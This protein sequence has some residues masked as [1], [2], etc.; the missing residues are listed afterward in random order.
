MQ[1][2]LLCNDKYTIYEDGTYKAIKLQEMMLSLAFTINKLKRE[3]EIL[4]EE[5]NMF[6]EDIDTLNEQKEAL[7]DHL[8]EEEVN[9][10]IAKSRLS[11]KQALVMSLLIEG[12]D[13]QEIADA[14]FISPNTV[15]SYLE[16]IYEK[17]NL[18]GDNRKIKAILIYLGK[19]KIEE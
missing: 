9:K 12:K 2:I 11:E 4:R 19:R 18:K 5:N 7:V 16:A 1:D 13:N 3:T 8:R 17:F 10:I 15:R 14:L 6:L